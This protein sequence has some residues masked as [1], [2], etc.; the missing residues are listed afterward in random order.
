MLFLEVLEVAVELDQLLILFLVI[1]GA[2][3]AG[4]VLCDLDDEACRLFD[5]EVAKGSRS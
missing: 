3:A 4:E 2:L 5:V 1:E